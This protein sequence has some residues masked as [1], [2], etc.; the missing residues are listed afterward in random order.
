MALPW[1]IESNRHKECP[2]ALGERRGVSPPVEVEL[3]ADLRRAARQ[4][5]DHSPEL[6]PIHL[7]GVCTK[8]LVERLV[9]FRLHIF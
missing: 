8:H 2:V 4:L 6:H 5:A 9:A 7:R 3:P 1:G